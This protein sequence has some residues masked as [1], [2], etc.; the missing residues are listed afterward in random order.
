VL[1][2][3]DEIAAGDVDPLA[4]RFVHANDDRAALLAAVAAGDAGARTL[5][6]RPAFEGDPC[7]G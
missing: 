1:G 2:L 6:L 4:G 5:G 3:V 7:A